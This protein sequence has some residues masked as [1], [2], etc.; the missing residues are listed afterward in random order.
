MV[1]CPVC[2]CFHVLIP[3]AS[4]ICHIIPMNWSSF[5][6]Y[7]T[8]QTKMNE[9]VDQTYWWCYML[10]PCRSSSLFICYLEVSDCIKV[11][12]LFLIYMSCSLF[13]IFRYGNIQEVALLIYKVAK[14]NAASDEFS[15]LLWLLWSVK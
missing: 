1:S 14:C 4:C 13:A 2:A 6:S 5:V 7:L 15:C 12:R 8:I 3:L 11:G 10:S 9:V